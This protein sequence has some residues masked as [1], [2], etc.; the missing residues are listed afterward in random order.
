MKIRGARECK[1]CGTQWAYYETGSVECPECGSLR[2]VGVDE[3]KQHTDAPA[4]LDL[5]EHRARFGEARSTLPEEGVDELKTT[6]RSYLRKR[7]F[8][9]GGELEPL[10]DTVLAAHELLHAV[11][12]YDRLADP[13]DPD[14]EYFLSLLSGADDGDRPAPAAVPSNMRPARGQGYANAVA[15]YRDD[16]LTY[17][18]DHP[19]ED[20][21]EVLG[22][23]RERVKRVESLQ[24]DV[25]PAAVEDLVT[26]ANEVGRYLREDDAAALTSARG[27]VERLEL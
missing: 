5:T 15:D 21:R 14:R 13:T 2:S 26:A 24:G 20:A 3:R 8:I 10:D 12:V 9:K 18:D 17:L 7:G 1:N 22:S 25:D 19:D 4:T 23:L 16:V 6:L 11:D 27:R